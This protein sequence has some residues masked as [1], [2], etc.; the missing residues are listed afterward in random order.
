[1]K[2]SELVQVIKEIIKEERSSRIDRDYIV[3]ILK[4]ALLN[5]QIKDFQITDDNKF[6]IVPDEETA[7][8]VQNIFAQSTQY[9]RF[10]SRAIKSWH[11]D[12]VFQINL[13]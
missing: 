3:K 8:S 11:G 6:L 2:K 10:L 4:N 7:Q 12:Y 9:K 1:M 13:K 5:N